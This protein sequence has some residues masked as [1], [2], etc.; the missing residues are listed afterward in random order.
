MFKNKLSVAALKE[1]RDLGRMFD[2]G[3]YYVPNE[4][5]VDGYDPEDDPFGLKLDQL[6]GSLRNRMKNIDSMKS[7]RPRLFAF[8]MLL[9]SNESLDTIKLNAEWD[10]ANTLKDPLLLW[11]HIAATYPQG[12]Y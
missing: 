11:Q 7:D 10:E 1:Y 4:I 5:Y 9:L 3:E 2:L 6:R 12:G 8:M